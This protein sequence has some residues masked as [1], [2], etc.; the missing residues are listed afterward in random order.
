MSPPTTTTPV[1][2]RALLHHADGDQVV[3]VET[4]ILDGRAGSLT[5]DEAGFELRTL[6]SAVTDW[7]DTDA[8]VALHHPEVERFARAFTGCDAVLFYPA[9]VR[10]R[11]AAMRDPSFIPIE[12]VHS[13]YT[14]GYRAMLA[15]PGHPYLDILGPSMTVAGVTPTDLA[16]ADRIVTVQLWRNIGAPNPDRPLAFC[17]G[18]TVAHDELVSHRVESYAGVRTEFDSFLVRPP[19]D[20]SDRRWYTFPAMTPDEVVVFRAFDSDRAARGEPFWTPH[21]A[22]VDPTAGPDAPERESVEIRAICL[23]GR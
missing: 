18:R 14:E 21:S 8:V 7:N 23:F 15:T 19:R 22:F 3:G 20:D 4:E 6:P 13:D 5:F 17:D 16:A 11:A 12:F 1:Y 10:S 9:I 2:C